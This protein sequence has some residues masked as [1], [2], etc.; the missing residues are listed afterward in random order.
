MLNNIRIAYKIK[1]EGEKMKK[2]LLLLGIFNLLS[3]TNAKASDWIAIND[4]SQVKW[5]H[6]GNDGKIYFRNLNEFDSSWL[7]CCYSYWIDPTTETGKI[8]WSVILTKMSTGGKL[9]LM[10]NDKATGGNIYSVGI[11]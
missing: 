1:K 4:M 5:Q 11:W 6:F 3:M 8:A 7:G 10:V 9:N 2:I